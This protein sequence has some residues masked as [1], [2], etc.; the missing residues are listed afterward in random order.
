MPPWLPVGLL[1]RIVAA[2]AAVVALAFIYHEIAEHFRDQGRA[3]IRAQWEA[4]KAERVRRT[5]EITNLWDAQRR[6][7]EE[8]IDERNKAREELASA[9]R[10]RVASLPPDVAG[11]RVPGVFVGVL[12]A[13]GNQANAAGTSGQPD[14]AAAAGAAGADAAELD[15]TLGLV[16]GWVAE[17]TEILAECR[18]QVDAWARFYRGLRAAQPS[19]GNSE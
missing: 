8:A 3:E 4:D 10:Q 19:E 17:V 11:T 2:I 5:T 12:R 18:D 16:A 9:T 7:T 1:V 15:S 14:A 6:K 13:A